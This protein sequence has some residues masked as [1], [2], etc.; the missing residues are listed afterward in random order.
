MKNIILASIFAFALSSCCNKGSSHCHDKKQCD[1]TQCD[2][3][4]KAC[5][6]KADSAKAACCHSADSAK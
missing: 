6:Q 3:S 5:C 4:K 1:S 2:S